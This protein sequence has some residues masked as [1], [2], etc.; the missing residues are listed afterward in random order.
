MKLTIEGE[1]LIDIEE[2]I[3][4]LAEEI[5][6]RRSLLA[7]GCTCDLRLPVAK[8]VDFGSGMTHTLQQRCD[9]KYAVCEPRKAKAEAA[10]PGSHE[11]VRAPAAD[12]MPS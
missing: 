12:A 9:D 3:I 8:R 6:L 11:R 7:D 1:S 2:K 10:H 5:D 4:A